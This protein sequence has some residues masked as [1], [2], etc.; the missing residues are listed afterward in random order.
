MRSWTSCCSGVYLSRFRETNLL[1]LTD[2]VKQRKWEYLDSDISSV[3]DIPLVFPK[4]ISSVETTPPL[5]FLQD[6]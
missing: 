4:V 2:T 1:V 6:S 3:E 5:H